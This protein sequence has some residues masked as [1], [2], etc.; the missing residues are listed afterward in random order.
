MLWYFN[1][2]GR[3]QGNRGRSVYIQKTAAEQGLKMVVGHKQQLRRTRTDPYTP[4]AATWK[5]TVIYRLA[6]QPPAGSNHPPFCIILLWQCTFKNQ[7]FVCF[8]LNKLCELDEELSP[9]FPSTKQSSGN[10]KFN[11][12]HAYWKSFFTSYLFL[13]MRYSNVVLSKPFLPPQDGGKPASCTFF[14][15]ITPL[16]IAVKI[17]QSIY[18]IY[19]WENMHSNTID[20]GKTNHS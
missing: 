18:H 17:R 12:L 6:K 13:P 10:R 3:Q 20:V 9:H 15:L 7:F 8:N 4:V 19:L 2:T 14:F 16:Y 5:L 1:K 11:I